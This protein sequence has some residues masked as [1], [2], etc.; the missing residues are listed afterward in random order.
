MVVATKETGKWCVYTRS[1]VSGLRSGVT[2][3]AARA[4]RCDAGQW[5]L[6]VLG[7]YLQ[8]RRTLLVVFEER[9]FLRI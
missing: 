5:P 2:R 4:A 8:N 1:S 6:A 3:V 9:H 7:G